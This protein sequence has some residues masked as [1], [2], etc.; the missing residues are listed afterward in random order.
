MKKIIIFF[1]AVFSMNIILA[2]SKAKDFYVASFRLLELDL[3]ARTLHPVIDQNGKK[4]ALIKV[5]TT[6]TGF[7]FDIGV[8]GITEVHQERGEIWVYI[9]QKAQRIT[10]RHPKFGVIRDFYF[11]V[12]IDSGNTY[13]M[14]LKVPQTADDIQ[15]KKLIIEHK[16]ETTKNLPLR[17]ES[18]EIKSVEK[19]PVT[20]KGFLVLADIGIRKNPSYGLRLGYY[21]KIGGYVNFRSNFVSASTDY[22]CFSDGSIENGSSI[23]TTGEEKHS[24]L[25][26]CAGVI[27][28]VTDWLSL[29]AGAGYGKSTLAWEDVNGKWAEVKDFSYKGV[30]IDAGV[31]FTINHF[32]IS[33]G[34][35]SVAFDWCELT[36]G[37]GVRF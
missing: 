19:K 3:D 20:N 22:N 13:E 26:L 25:N 8:M 28:Q 1:I 5:V 29:Y 9:P 33:A 4:A 10:I 23:W 7:D 30:A 32:A 37:F 34:V 27:T 36:L 35:N 14:N 18:G 6:Y 2:Q 15:P 17:G 16:F 11:P 12:P 24:R 31:V 21:K